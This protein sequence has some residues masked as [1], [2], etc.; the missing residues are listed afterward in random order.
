MPRINQSLFLQEAGYD[1]GAADEGAEQGGEDGQAT[2][3]RE[4]PESE[5]QERDSCQVAEDERDQLVT[6]GGG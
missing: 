6:W 2:G 3:E 1:R 5:A 4:A